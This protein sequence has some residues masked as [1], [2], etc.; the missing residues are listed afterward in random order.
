MLRIRR[1][2][3]LLPV[4][5][6]AA[7]EATSA[8]TTDLDALLLSVS[9]SP[10]T[11]IAGASANIKLTVANPTLRTVEFQ[12]C[13]IYFWVEDAQTGAMV[14]GS[15]S[16]GCLAVALVYDPVRLGPFESRTFTWRWTGV[17]TQDVP[18]GRYRLYGWLGW[19]QRA[20]TPVAVAV[21][22]A[23]E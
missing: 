8:P 20:S 14:G 4:I 19:E 21:V 16:L 22:A 2:A 23:E 15:R 3:R 17:E 12:T 9:V 7:C 13:P 5:A 18:P 10:A 1:L 11:V 6:L